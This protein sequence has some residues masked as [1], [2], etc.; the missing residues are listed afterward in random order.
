MKTETMYLVRRRWALLVVL[1]FLVAA[2]SAIASIADRDSQ[3]ARTPGGRPS[4][5]PRR[6]QPGGLP[7]PTPSPGS[8]VPS[9]IPGYLLIA[10]RGNNR[11]LL[12]DS[13]GRILWTYP[14]AG[15]KPSFPFHFDDDAFFSKS[16]RMI[17][18]QQEEQQTAQVISFPRGKVLWEYG[19][20][21][22]RGSAAGYLSTP[23]D[24]YLLPNGT[25]T[26]A[27]VRNCR[28]L[29]IAPDRTIR[30]QLGTTVVCT[31]DPPRS[32]GSP[33][34]DT[35]LP[36]GG[37]LVTEINGSWVDAIDSSGRL[38]WSVHAPARY[39]S[40]AQWLGNGT[41]ML[42]D[43]SFPG[44]V[45]IMNTRGDVLWSYGPSSGDGALNHPSLAIMLPNGLIAVN[46]DYRDRVVL[47]SRKENHIVWQYGH[48]DVA[49]SGPRL[50]NTPDGMDFLPF[51]VAMTDP[52]LRALLPQGQR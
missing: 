17:I 36:D 32:F 26:V 42:A 48:T 37:T 25:V 28:I 10:D 35:P 30:R 11:M 47:I 23:D 45:L 6:T 19:H 2:G 22:V 43:Y 38:E 18:S 46:D 29:F 20:P 52:L 39:P 27:D 24:A 15:V 31:H 4:V 50:L 49:G 12:V 13:R 1:A 9:P 33:N 8:A 5:G 51:D 14:P 44:H 41:F 21:N 34:G 16:Y 40:D 3:R 7:S